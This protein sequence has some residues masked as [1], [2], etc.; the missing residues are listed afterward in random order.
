MPNTGLC[1]GSEAFF[2][3]LQHHGGGFWHARSSLWAMPTSLPTGDTCGHD[4]TL[5]I[6]NSA[7]SR[8]IPHTG[9][10]VPF[11]RHSCHEIPGDVT[12]TPSMHGKPR[13]L[14]RAYRPRN[15]LREQNT[16]Y[17]ARDAPNTCPRAHENP[18]VPNSITRRH[19][20]RPRDGLFRYA[21]R[22]RAGIP[23]RRRARE[24]RS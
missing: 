19:F 24:G 16:W 23:P 6:P 21:G 2:Y 5:R 3:F 9:L 1:T 14:A 7:R 22:S 8:G 20:N 11:P 17:A 4:V 10:R 12:R 15:P 13:R 18:R